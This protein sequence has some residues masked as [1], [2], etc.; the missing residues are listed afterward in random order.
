MVERGEEHEALAMIGG[1]E[2]FPTG[3]CVLDNLFRV[4]PANEFL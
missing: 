1:V 3:F 4:L 2:S